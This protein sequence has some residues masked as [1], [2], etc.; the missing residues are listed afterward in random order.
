MRIKQS[1]VDAAYIRPHQPAID[2]P[3]AV[4]PLGANLTPKIA[5]GFRNAARW[6]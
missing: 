4:V 2:W 6:R 3:P 1:Q 5:T